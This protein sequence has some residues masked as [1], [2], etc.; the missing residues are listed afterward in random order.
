MYLDQLLKLG[1]FRFRVEF[2]DKT[3]T[4]SYTETYAICSEAM[5]ICFVKIW[6]FVFCAWKSLQCLLT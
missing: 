6:D 2:E 5:Y 3:R 1:I 4:F